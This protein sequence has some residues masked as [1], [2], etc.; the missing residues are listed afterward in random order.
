MGKRWKEL[1]DFRGKY[2]NPDTSSQ[3]CMC[4]SS[5]L[6]LC[7]TLWPGVPCRRK[8]V[9]AQFQEVESLMQGGV[10]GAGSP[11]VTSSPTL[12]KREN[13]L[14]VGF[15]Q[16]P[17]PVIFFLHQGCIISPNSTNNW[18]PRTLILEPVKNM[19]HT[20]NKQIKRI[21]SVLGKNQCFSERILLPM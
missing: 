3:P 2:A 8:V 16:S 7:S 15:A 9:W 10:F 4:L 11:K 20:G 5:C 17:P 19:P 21:N 1:S 18:G 12:R 6:Q 14:E 13:K